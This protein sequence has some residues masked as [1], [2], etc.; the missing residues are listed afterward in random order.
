MWQ[1][2]GPGG[3]IYAYLEWH[4]PHNLGHRR[5]C[6]VAQ[7]EDAEPEGR[8]ANPAVVAPTLTREN[9]S[10]LIDAI[11]EGTAPDPPSRAEIL[12]Y[13]LRLVFLAVLVLGFWWYPHDQ[14]S[15]VP[16]SYSSAIK[17]AIV[18]YLGGGAQG[19]LVNWSVA[20]IDARSLTIGGPSNEQESVS[21]PVLPGQCSAIAA[22]LKTSCKEGTIVAPR[23]S[24]VWSQP[25]AVYLE[26]P[27][28]LS[29][30]TTLKVALLPTTARNGL[31]GPNPGSRVVGQSVAIGGVNAAP[32]T[33]CSGPANGLTL[34]AAGTS[35]SVPEK[36]IKRVPCGQGLQVAVPPLKGGKELRQATFG[37]VTSF[38]LKATTGRLDAQYLEGTL[39]VGSSAPSDIAPPEEALLEGNG[40]QVAISSSGGGS[41]LSIASAQLSRANL[42]PD[43]NTGTSVNLAEDSASPSLPGPDLVPPLWQQN[44]SFWLAT[45]ITVFL[46]VLAIGFS[47]RLSPGR[48]PIKTRRLKSPN[49]V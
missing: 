41:Q 38:G 40:T 46:G 18:L 2:G 28:G 7:V 48:K 32:I 4:A 1:K 24:V 6:P 13:G 49:T 17:G 23:I 3:P 15:P 37:G 21:L 33:W 45:F 31:A 14:R 20:G 5:E 19:G 26:T 9:L 25:Q 35:I 22:A 42:G 27:V 8:N 12:K 44:K 39:N 30:A 10:Q 16:V 29:Q 43:S 34:E 11:K 36:E 47:L